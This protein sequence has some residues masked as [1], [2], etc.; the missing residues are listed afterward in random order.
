MGQGFFT[1]LLA[2]LLNSMNSQSWQSGFCEPAIASS[3]VSNE[4]KS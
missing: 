1:G 3:T 2:K 4:L